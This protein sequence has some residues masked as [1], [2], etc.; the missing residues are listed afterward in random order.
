M[1]SDYMSCMTLINSTPQFGANIRQ[2]D[3]KFFTNCFCWR[4]QQGVVNCL[5]KEVDQIVSML[6]TATEEMLEASGNQLVEHFE[7]IR[8]V[9]R[10]F[11]RDL[12]KKFQQNIKF[13]QNIQTI[14]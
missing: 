10:M 13:C 12:R 9:H 11:S 5:T 14:F 4:E 1:I 8:L 3:Q 2:D 7:N 6:D